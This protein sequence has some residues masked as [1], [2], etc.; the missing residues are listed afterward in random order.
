MN[1][2]DSY[3]KFLYEFER[4]PDDPTA[5]KRRFKEIP[6]YETDWAERMKKGTY[7][8]VPGE[9]VEKFS[10]EPKELGT[11]TKKPYTWI[12]PDTGEY[13]EDV[14]KRLDKL[15][16][17]K[18]NPATGKEERDFTE[19]EIAKYGVYSSLAAIAIYTSYKV[20]KNFFSKYAKLCVKAAD[21]KLCMLDLK[22]KALVEQVKSLQLSLRNCN[23]LKDVKQR[24]K[25][26]TKLQKKIYDINEKIRE[27]SAEIIV[28]GRR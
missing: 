10:T 23:K 24:S 13:V 9:E 4:D 6:S 5:Y 26:L 7:S 1:L 17:Y 16:H 2:L 12:V 28:K 21:K 15:P 11:F 3:L 19:Y 22:K 25:C 8:D 14:E 20:Y 18:L 27:V